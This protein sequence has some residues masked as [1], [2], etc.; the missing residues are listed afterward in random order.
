[1]DQRGPDEAAADAE[2]ARDI[3]DKKESPTPS[4]RL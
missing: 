2:Q 4:A 1:M 3:P